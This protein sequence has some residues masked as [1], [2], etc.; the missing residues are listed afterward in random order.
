MS[1]Q[2]DQVIEDAF[3]D[4]ADQKIH[5]LLDQIRRNIENERIPLTSESL[6]NEVDYLNQH[7]NFGWQLHISALYAFDAGG[8]I[9]AHS[10]NTQGAKKLEPGSP[11]YNIN[12][13]EASLGEVHEREASTGT[14][15]GD[16]LLPMT[17][18]NGDTAGIEAEVDI[19]GLQQA[20]SAFDGPFEQSMWNTILLSSAVMLVLLGG[21]THFW[22]KNDGH[23]HETPQA[24]QGLCGN[25]CLAS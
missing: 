3:L 12:L 17:L 16:Y 21:L 6:A 13:R 22:L 14:V 4:Q 9:L 19:T 18:N 11:Y 5:L 7:E 20:V 1:R 15:K 23:H 10:Q 8:R 25:R 2:T 24:F